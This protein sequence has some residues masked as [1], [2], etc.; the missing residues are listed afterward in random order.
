MFVPKLSVPLT[1]AIRTSEGILVWLTNLGLAAGALIE[2]STLPPKE[3]AIVASAVTGLHVVSRTLLKVTALQQGA[4][5]PAPAT[6]LVEELAFNVARKLKLPAAVVD[7]ATVAKIVSVAVKA[8]GDPRT[9][10][11]S[12]EEIAV[13]DAEEF[14]SQPPASVETIVRPESS[15][16]PDVP[17]PEPTQ[18]ADVVQQVAEAV[19]AAQPPAQAV[20]AAPGA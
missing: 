3:A 17:T 16:K 6:D 12:V 15:T 5:L 8:V 4:G 7:D 13:S 2:P 20:P 18:P 19:P 9:A 10:L 11:H 1:K 14:A